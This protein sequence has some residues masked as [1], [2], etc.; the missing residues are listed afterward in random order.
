VKN[1]NGTFTIGY[2]IQVA[3]MGDVNLSNV[4]VTDQLTSTFPAPATFTVDSLSSVGFATNAGYNGNGNPNLLAASQTLA[5]GAQGVINLTVT[6]TKNGTLTVSFNNQATVGAVSPASQIVSASA[7]ALA[8]LEVPVI[9][10]TKQVT[11]L[12]PNGTNFSVT[13]RI[14]AFNAGDVALKNV[15]VTDDLDSTFRASR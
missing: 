8:I 12:V 6:V 2:S 1:P 3:N 13:M 7:T 10:I 5:V 4:Q 14:D 9:E 15:Q 11:A